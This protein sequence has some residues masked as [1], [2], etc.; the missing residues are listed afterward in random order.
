MTEALGRGIVAG[1]E[2]SK[3]EL[4]EVLISIGMTSDDAVKQLQKMLLDGRLLVQ[5]GS[6]NFGVVGNSLI[7]GS[8][9]L[10]CGLSGI[11]FATTNS[12]AAKGFYALSI[13]FSGTAAT[14]GG[15]AAVARKCEISEVAFLS[16][17]FGAAFLLLGNQAH[18]AA[19]KIEGKPVPARFRRAAPSFGLHNPRNNAAFIMPFRASRV[20]EVIPFEQIGKTVGFSISIYCYGRMII[21]AYRYGQQLIGKYKKKKLVRK[22]LLKI[23]KLLLGSIYTN[24]AVWK[25]KKLYYF[26]IS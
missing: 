26:A 5:V 2:L 24:K 11:G 20:I 4:L 18:A 6:E 25:R 7:S 3:P 21:T 10:T 8:G 23:S 19:L 14:T 1:I 22:K 9:V 17:T 15:M 16:E 13:G 12:P